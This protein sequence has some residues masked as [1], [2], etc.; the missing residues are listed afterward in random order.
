MSDKQSRQ[1]AR[2]LKRL[3]IPDF[4]HMTKDKLMQFVSMTSRMDPEVAKAAIAQFP[5]FAKMCKESLM[6]Y[7][8]IVLRVIEQDAEGDS[9][10]FDFYESVR[11][12]IEDTLY[13]DG[14]S[15]EQKQW[16]IEQLKDLAA[17]VAAQEQAN[18]WHRIKVIGT[19][20]ITVAGVLAS[21]AALLGGS[22]QISESD[23][24]DQDN[25]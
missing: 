15:F 25:Y 23:D 7:K 6:D 22:T 16:C 14:L 11:R 10:V 12:A 21:A 20:G 3:N 17:Q 2:I 19:V 9:R 1:E 5:D 13:Q 24:F 4:R 18:K 8:E